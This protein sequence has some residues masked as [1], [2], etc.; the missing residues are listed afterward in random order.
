VSM[1]QSSTSSSMSRISS[2]ACFRFFEITLVALPF[3]F[4]DTIP[5]L[6][7]PSAKMNAAGRFL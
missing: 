7:R 6:R 5:E 3:Y 1:E 2:I 4:T